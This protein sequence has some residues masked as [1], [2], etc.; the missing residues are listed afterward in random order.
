MNNENKWVKK[1]LGYQQQDGGWGCFHSLSKP[2]REMPMTTEQAL[3]RLW[4]LGLARTDE[5]IQRAIEHMKAVI[6]HEQILPDRRERVLNW[7]YFD[8]MMMAAWIKQ[9][10]HADEQ[11]IPIA[12]FWAGIVSVAF[13]NGAFD[14]Q[15]YKREYRE[16]ISKLHA[17]E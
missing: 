12:R 2:T 11:A 5:P 14:E 9:F 3:R 6:N 7:D 13:A 10:D 15:A 16:R 8:Q 17:N 1:I 4:H